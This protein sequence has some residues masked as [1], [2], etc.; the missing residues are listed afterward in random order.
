MLV[1]DDQAQ[2]SSE[3]FLLDA[4]FRVQNSV[5]SLAAA[6]KYVILS[7]ET[8]GR[9]QRIA[10]LTRCPGIDFGIRICGRASHVARMAEKVGGAPEKLAAMFDLQ[11]LQMIN[12]FGK[13]LSERPDVVCV[14]HDIDVVETVEGQVQLLHER[15]RSF[16]LFARCRGVVR[17]DVPW[18]A[19]CATAEHIAARPAECVPE[20]HREAQM[21]FHPLAKDHAILV[22]PAI[23][24]IVGAIRS[25]IANGGELGE[26]VSGHG[27][28][29]LE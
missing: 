6:P 28:S 29:L 17:A 22:V 12:R 13:A 25:F 7:P 1:I 2:E 21:I 5:I 19:K 10:Y 18:A 27:K 8:M 3:I 14:R 4:D 11:F 20:A 9:L 23:G 15:Q 26:I 24:E 16:P